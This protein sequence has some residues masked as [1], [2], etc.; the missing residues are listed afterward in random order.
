VPQNFDTERFDL[1]K[2]RYVEVK[3]QYQFKTS[4]T[5]STMQNLD[6]NVGMKRAGDS[7]KENIRTPAKETLDN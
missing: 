7:I 5:F 2:L 1:K 4:S 6:S 3:G